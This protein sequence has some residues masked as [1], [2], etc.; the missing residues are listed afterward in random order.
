MNPLPSPRLTLVSPR[1]WLYCIALLLAANLTG[2][3]TSGN[4]RDPLEGYNR[5]MFTFND[6]VDKVALKPVAKVYQAVTPS[7]AQ[8][9][10]GNF[11]GN[12]GDL[13]TAVNNLL[14]GK[15]NDAM[16]DVTRVAMNSTFGLAGVIDIASDA[17]LPKHKEDFGQTLGKWG[18]APGP[19]IVLPLLGPSTLRDTVA[20]PLDFAGDPWNYKKPDRARYAGN[21]LRVVDQRSGLLD[22]S[23][24]LEEAALDRYEFIRDGFLQRRESK[25]FDGEMP[26]PKSSKGEGESATKEAATVG[27]LT[28][29]PEVT[30][31]AVDAASAA[32]A[33][34]K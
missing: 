13:W 7:F 23:N 1:R 6:T 29:E 22:A 33:E 26:Q 34:E 12:L 19:Y 32:S 9:A 8:T 25:V 31:A 18:I 3:A 27:A 16:T 17:G 14:Q 11:F 28:A 5:A 2:C 15:V 4:P 30:V 21:V 20:F 10:V 24:L